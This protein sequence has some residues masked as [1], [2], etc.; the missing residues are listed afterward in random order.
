MVSIQAS[1]TAGSA[2]YVKKAE[3]AVRLDLNP[4]AVQNI[5]HAIR[6]RDGNRPV[7]F[8]LISLPLYLVEELSRILNDIR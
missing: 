4:P 2:L 7:T 8:K 5:K 3:T 6:T 1:Q